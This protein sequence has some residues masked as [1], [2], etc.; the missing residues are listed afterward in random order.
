MQAQLVEEHPA[1]HARRIFSHPDKELAQALARFIGVRLGAC[2]SCG[3]PKIVGPHRPAHPHPHI[4]TPTPSLPAHP[5]ARTP[6][7]THTHTP[8]AEFWLHAM[9]QDFRSALD[10][11][12]HPRLAAGPC[13]CCK[14]CQRQ[15]CCLTLFHGMLWQQHAPCL[16]LWLFAFGFCKNTIGLGFSKTIAFC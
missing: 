6:T 2:Q 13:L 4:H 15:I 14:T 10:R 12:Y 11:L 8:V 16:R 9:L 7:C 1:V 3:A 5:P